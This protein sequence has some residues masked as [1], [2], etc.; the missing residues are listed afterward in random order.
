M[1]LL[2][3]LLVGDEVGGHIGVLASLNRRSE[4]ASA[5]ACMDSTTYEPAVRVVVS[6]GELITG[7]LLLR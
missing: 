5:K 1:R 6:V 2:C 7:N 4:V 3:Q